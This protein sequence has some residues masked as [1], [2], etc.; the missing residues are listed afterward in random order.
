VNVQFVPLGNIAEIDMGQAPKGDSYNELGDGV[1]LIAGASD[2]GPMS[3]KPSRF[4]NAPTKISQIGDVIVCIRATIGDLNYSDRNYCLGRGVAG[5]RPK[6]GK[7]NERYLWRALEASADRLKSKG[8]G[9]T[10]L[11]VSKSDIADLEIPLPPLDE[12]KRIAAILDKADE[13]RRLRQRAI[14]RLNSLGQAIFVEMFGDGSLFERASL[15]F[16]G[17]VSTGSTPP[18]SDADSFGGSVPFVTPGDLG[19]GGV[20]KRTLTESGA[21]KSRLVSAGAAFVCC[22]GATIGK[23]GQAIERSAFNQQINAVEWGARIDP[24]FGFYALQQ[25]R[26]VIIHKGKGASTTLPILKK[27]EFEKLQIFLPVMNEQIEFAQ[28]I[29]RI[30]AALAN[31]SSHG[32]N[33]GVLFG[34]LQHRAFA[35]EL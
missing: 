1:P 19:S 22:I 20:V 6:N 29:A 14:D 21:E 13:L 10:F 32:D 3:P 12:Q 34:S 25:I 23:M 35:G 27:S 8:R 24:T 7:L 5:L 4:T 11:Q 28:R 2:F 33:L 16:L 18:T 26:D 17:I 31:I 30:R 9:A 15:K